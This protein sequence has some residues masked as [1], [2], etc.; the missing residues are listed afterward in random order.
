MGKLYDNTMGKLYDNTMGK[1][2][3]NN[4]R[5]KLKNHSMR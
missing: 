2:Y 5:G 4:I 3:Y 1:L